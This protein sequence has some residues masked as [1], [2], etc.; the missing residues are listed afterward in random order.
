VNELSEL[1]M[2]LFAFGQIRSFEIFAFIEYR[3]LKIRVRG[4]SR[5][6]KM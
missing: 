1:K 6:T 3:D 4:H 2:K 5:S